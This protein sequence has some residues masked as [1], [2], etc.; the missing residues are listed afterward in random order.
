MFK[1]SKLFQN[2]SKEIKSS[3]SFYEANIVLIPKP[4]KN[5]RSDNY[6]HFIYKPERNI[7]QI[8]QSTTNTVYYSKNV[9]MVLHHKIY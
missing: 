7:S 3:S 2:I 4:V 5:I 9:R 6:K 8:H 1:L